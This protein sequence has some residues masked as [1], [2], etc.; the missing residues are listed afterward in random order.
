MSENAVGPDKLVVDMVKAFRD[1]TVESMSTPSVKNVDTEVSRQDH[2]GMAVPRWRR[3][4]DLQVACTV[5]M[6][7]CRSANS[8]VSE[9]LAIDFLKLLRDAADASTPTPSVENLQAFFGRL[10][11]VR[12]DG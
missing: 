5:P 7:R 9:Q 11:L 12:N 10:D 4:I 8:S 6:F 3:C 2:M 1:A